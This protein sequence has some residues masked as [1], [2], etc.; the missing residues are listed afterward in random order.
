MNNHRQI[1]EESGD[2]A[3]DIPQDALQDG[4]QDASQGDMQEDARQ[5]AQ[6][7]A[8]ISEPCLLISEEANFKTSLIENMLAEEKIPYISRDLGIGGYFKVLG[9]YSV[10]GTSIYVNKQDYPRAKELVDVYF[11]NIP[12][13]QG[14]EPIEE[15][16]VK[17]VF[18]GR[19]IMKIFIAL[20]ILLAIALAVYA[21]I[22]AF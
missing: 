5:T 21:A 18:I 14:F 1:S 7:A 16:D 9:G 8:H 2:T 17:P 3:Q 13:E 4:V 22:S 11:S 15:S 12:S 6:N 19:T 20:F 10:F